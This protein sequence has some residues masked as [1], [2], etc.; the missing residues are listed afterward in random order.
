MKNNQDEYNE[1]IK[2]AESAL[3][4]ATDG[5]KISKN[6]V[7]EDLCYNAQQAVEKSLKAYLIFIDKKYPRTHNIEELLNL[8]Q[9]E[10][11]IIPEKIKLA[12][13]L[14]DYVSSRYP[15]DFDEI[16]SKEYHESVK[17]AKNVFDWVRK[18]TD[19]RNKLF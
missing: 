19:K 1:W 12:K 8:L 17:I 3:R 14:T 9:S 6:I 16:T 5:K 10:K 13:R 15:G 18:Q 4:I 7:L 11:I 2:R